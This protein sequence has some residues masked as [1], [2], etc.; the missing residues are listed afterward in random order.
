M[1]SYKT[2][3]CKV[4]LGGENDQVIPKHGVTIAELHI[5]KTLHG[6]QAVIDVQPHGVRNNV[7][8]AQ[9]VDRLRQTY[10]SPRRKVV[11]E[12][13]PGAFP[14]LPNSLASIGL[15]LYAAPVE[16]PEEEGME[17][18][19]D[20][21]AAAEPE[22]EIDEEEAAMRAHFRAAQEKRIRGPGG[23]FV[24]KNPKP[25]PVDDDLDD[26]PTPP[27]EAAGDQPAATA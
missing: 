18:E 16:L 12:L 6:N 2:F 1:A 21:E 24:S 7:V 10:D 27:A 22:E 5:L 17:A 19:G 3:S 4:R 26:A 25:E 20:A 11:E 23:K 8:T 14:S 13:Y 9:E 15:K